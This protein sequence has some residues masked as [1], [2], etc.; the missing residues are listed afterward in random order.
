MKH[1]D[2]NVAEV[3]EDARVGSSSKQSDTRGS[4]IRQIM[5]PNGLMVISVASRLSQT[6]RQPLLFPPKPPPYSLDNVS[7]DTS[8][9]H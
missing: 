7:A 4:P 2:G 1:E 6:C 8:A 3:L 9:D 5:D